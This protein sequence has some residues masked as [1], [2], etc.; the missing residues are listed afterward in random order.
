[1]L[2]GIVVEWCPSEMNVRVPPPKGGVHFH[3]QVLALR[4]HLL[5]INFVRHMLAYCNI[6]PTQLTPSAWRIALDFEAL[7]I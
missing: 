5:L 3:P 7:F 6:I 4:V 2:P 1:M